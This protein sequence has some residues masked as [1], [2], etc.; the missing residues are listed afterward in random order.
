MD[1]QHRQQRPLLG[2]AQRHRAA[3]LD[4]LKRPQDPKLDHSLCPAINATTAPPRPTPPRSRGRVPAVNR[5]RPL[6]NRP[7]ASFP[8]TDRTR[9]STTKEALAMTTI[10]RIA[11]GAVLALALGASAAPALAVPF[12]INANGSEVPAGSPSMRIPVATPTSAVSTAP[13]IVRVTAPGSGF[14]WGDA[15]I[16]AAGGF[17]LSMAGLGAALAISQ[18][19]ARRTTA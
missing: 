6:L 2:A 7:I 17:A 3:L 8:P 5:H 1:H 11:I 15:G 16:G 10:H 9:R 19:R 14:D 4:H 12:D 18:N 13:T